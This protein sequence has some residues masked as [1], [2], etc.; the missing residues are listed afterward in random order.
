MEKESKGLEFNHRSVLLDECME[1]LA[2]KPDGIYID[3]TAGGGGHSFAI[4]SH[5]SE[6]GLLV[7]TDRDTEAIAA[8]T[9]RLEPLT[10]KKEIYH[11]K[12]HCLFYQI[13]KVHIKSD[14][15]TS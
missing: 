13:F 12:Y 8:C 15:H 5:L 3:G 7:C 6:N 9:A 4:G 1:G 14:N 11:G 10:C 2:I